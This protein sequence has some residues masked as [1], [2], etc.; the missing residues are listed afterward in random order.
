MAPGV[1]GLAQWFPPR[2]SQ[3]FLE[4]SLGSSPAYWAIFTAVAALLSVH[5][6]CVC[7]QGAHVSKPYFPAPRSVTGLENRVVMVSLSSFSLPQTFS[8]HLGSS[9]KSSKGCGWSGT[10]CSK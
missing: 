9:C 2:G 8:V 1:W 3:G 10:V 6:F 5:T 7:V 4:Q